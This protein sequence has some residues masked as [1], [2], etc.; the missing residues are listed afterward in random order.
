MLGTDQGLSVYSEKP[1]LV[2]TRNDFSGTL[3]F[4]VQDGQYISVYPNSIEGGLLMNSQ[5]PPCLKNL[6][7]MDLVMPYLNR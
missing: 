7:P 5:K 3:F 6:I 1:Q 4:N 2:H